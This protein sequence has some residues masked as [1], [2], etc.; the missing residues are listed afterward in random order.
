[1]RGPLYNCR[2]QDLEGRDI[3]EV[4]C[5]CGYVQQFRPM[6][7]AKLWAT[8]RIPDHRRLLD[9]KGQFRCSQCGSRGGAS[10][11]VK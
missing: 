3:V 6:Q 10:L 5:P 4:E 9:A 8:K 2:L 11:R 7:L 1:M